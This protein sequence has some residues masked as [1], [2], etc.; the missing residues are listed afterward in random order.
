MKARIVGG[1]FDG[2]EFQ[3]SIETQKEIE[4]KM[5]KYYDVK[6]YCR[7][8]KVFYSHDAK[9]VRGESSGYNYVRVPLP[10]ANDRWS[11]A[12][13]DWVKAF[14]SHFNKTYSPWPHHC[15]KLDCVRYLWIKI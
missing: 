13:F 9:F 11:F 1:E 8:H 2:V 6:E 3:V 10:E 12:A 4:E 5:N 14:C 15:N 7:K